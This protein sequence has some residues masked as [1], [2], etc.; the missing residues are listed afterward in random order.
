MNGKLAAEFSGFVTEYIV[1]PIPADLL[2]PGE[3]QLA[4]TCKQTTGGQAID[5]H[6]I[7]AE[8]VPTLPEPKRP[9]RP[10]PSE[11]IT[12][13][14]TRVTP[15]NAWTEYPRPQFVR[16]QWENLNG[17]WDYAIT[18]KEA[19]RPAKWDGQILV[20]FAIESKLSGVGRLLHGDQALWYRRPLPAKANDGR[21]LL[22]NFEAVDYH[23]DVWV[24]NTKV[25]SHTG[26]STPF[27]FDV[28]GA[29]KPD[30]DNHLVVR[31]EDATDGFQLK[32]KQT[33]DP[34]GIWYTQVSGIWGTVWTEEVPESHL[35]SVSIHTSND[36]TLTFEFVATGGADELPIEVTAT[37]DG[38][39]VARD[40][41]SALRTTLKIP[42]PRRW[43]PASP[44][45][46]E[47]EFRYGADVVKSYAG[48]REIGKVKDADGH[49][50][51][52]LNGEPIFHWGPLDQ[53]WW[54]DGLL[55]P[56]SDE[57][58]RWD[59]DYLKAAGFNMI[60]KH[61]KIEPRRFYAYCDEVGMLVWQDQPSGGPKPPWTRLQP[62]PQDAVWP[63]ADHEQYLYELD[64]M[65]TTL[66][67]H[68][69]IVQWVPFNEA[70]GQHRT[71]AVGEW[72]VERDPTR[73]VNIASGGNFWP[74]GDIVDHHSYPHPEW[75]HEL[76]G[77]RFDGFIK[78]MG[79]FGGHGLPSP[80]HLWDNSRRNWGYGGLPKNASEYKDR[81][82]ESLRILAELKRKHGIA[83]G[84]YTQTTDVE[85]E[86]NGLVS[87]DRK[88]IKI[89]ATELKKLHARLLQGE[90]PPVP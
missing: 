15:E 5:V 52:T 3:N 31:V 36:G 11:L 61:I 37:L 22:L 90:T 27:S 57:A 48:I 78:V 71:M 41:G 80:G 43:S 62:N 23:C 1:H 34:R 30:G 73:H 58:M 75:P 6:I 10:F 83:G 87:Y 86:I 32:G 64:R 82:L 85:G 39:K 28:T 65:I 25:G 19:P 72:T 49:L 63:D 68:P 88:V 2:K 45:L 18:T 76:D 20:P 7:D 21:R 66:E 53:G 77:G 70:W 29:L 4:V 50:R 26:G 47:L 17:L 55:T 8:N 67:N 74:V 69:S 16:D 54:P 51:F 79:E 24:N 59:V 84:V 60:R 56:P 14:G 12:E 81:Y 46:Y 38:E 9:E 42:E 35:S 33:T 44:T 40:Q 89:P 13:W